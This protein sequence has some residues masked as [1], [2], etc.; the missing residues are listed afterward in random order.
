MYIIFRRGRVTERARSDTA[1]IGY[2]AGIATEK[3]ALLKT[4][5]KPELRTL[6]PPIIIYF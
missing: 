6:N 4:S 5:E 2:S 3:K 1:V